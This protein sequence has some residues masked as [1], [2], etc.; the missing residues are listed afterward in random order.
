MEC[1][2][3]LVKPVLETTQGSEHKTGFLVVGL[4]IQFLFIFNALQR[5][6]KCW[7]LK[8]VFLL[9][10]TCGLTSRF[11]LHTRVVHLFNIVIFL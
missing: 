6:P 8:T 1:L 10:N 2:S 4:L 3:Y 9:L 7:S 5:D 11:D